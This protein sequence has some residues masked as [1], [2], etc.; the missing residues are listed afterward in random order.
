MA[1]TWWGVLLAMLVGRSISTIKLAV[2]ILNPILDE[3]FA[4]ASL[5]RRG[6]NLHGNALAGFLPSD[7]PEAGSR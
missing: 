1:V 3:A 7:F 6:D 4:A 2:H 5:L